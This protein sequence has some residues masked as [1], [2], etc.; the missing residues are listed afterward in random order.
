[1][2]SVLQQGIESGELLSSNLIPIR[3]DAREFDFPTDVTAGILLMRHCTCFPLYLEKLRLAGAERL[4]TNARW[5]MS[6]EE[7]FLSADRELFNDAEMG[8]YACSCGAV[9]FK[10]G[11]AEQWSDKM[12]EV[13]HEVFDCPQRKQF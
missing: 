13:T 3:A 11:A 1:M 10:V 6:V 12:D 7:I 5:H 8:W 9:G 2:S 4:I